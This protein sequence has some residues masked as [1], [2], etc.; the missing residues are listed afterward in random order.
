MKIPS[1]TLIFKRYK[2]LLTVQNIGLLVAVVIALAWV[3]GSVVALQKNY[4]YQREVDANNQQIE[5]QKLQNKTF[6]YQQAYLK[7]DEYLELSARAKLGLALP[8]EN[9][10]LLP[11]SEHVKD[12]LSFRKSTLAVVETESNFARW[13]HFLF[14]VH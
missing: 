8:G 12:D 1:I 9:L 7:S 10:V 5:L 4:K 3:W 14:E 11:D 13:M 6:R 2:Y